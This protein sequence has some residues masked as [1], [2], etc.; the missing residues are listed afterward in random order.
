MELINLGEIWKIDIIAGRNPI[1]TFGYRDRANNDD[2]WTFYRCLRSVSFEGISR[3]EVINLLVHNKY[4]TDRIFLSVLVSF[5]IGKRP[6]RLIF[7][8]HDKKVVNIEHSS[9][10]VMK[11][12]IPAFN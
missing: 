11:I 2:R 12:Y 6:I 7:T 4:L 3:T 10:K 9:L 5:I 8:K 1:V